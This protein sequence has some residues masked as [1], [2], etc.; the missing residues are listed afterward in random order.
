VVWEGIDPNMN[1]DASYYNR[2]GDVGVAESHEPSRAAPTLQVA[3][4]RT[5]A[6]IRYRVNEPC[7]YSL[8]ILDLT[9]RRVVT[10][11]AGRAEPGLRVI[12]W[13][14]VAGDGQSVPSG[15]YFIRLSAG[16]ETAT[17]KI[18]VVRNQTE[19]R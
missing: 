1:N 8:A 9:G 14:Y 7:L 6:A 2:L 19:R 4:E 18:A 16:N 12:H 17:R 3:C 10:L 11:A 5:G 13:N 15:V